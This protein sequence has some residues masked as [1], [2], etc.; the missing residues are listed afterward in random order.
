MHTLWARHCDISG[1]RSVARTGS[2]LGKGAELP[3]YRM[4]RESSSAHD[5]RWLRIGQ[6][7]YS[8]LWYVLKL[9]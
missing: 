1:D 9:I 3:R 4:M 5:R 2:T 6:C 7:F 8:V